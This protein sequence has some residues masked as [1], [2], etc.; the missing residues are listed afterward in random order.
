MGIAVVAGSGFPCRKTTTY[1]ADVVSEGTD[2][3]RARP[4]HRRRVA[5]EV[6]AVLAR[7]ASAGQTCCEV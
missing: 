5:V 6:G 1:L 3:G 4:R 2:G 7:H